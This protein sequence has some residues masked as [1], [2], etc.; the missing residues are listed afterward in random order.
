MI[1][2]QCFNIFMLNSLL[3]SQSQT[4][5]YKARLFLITFAPL[6]LSL[7]HTGNHSLMEDCKVYVFFLLQLFFNLRCILFRLAEEQ[8]STITKATDGFL[9][10]KG[11]RPARLL[12]I[13]VPFYQ[14]DQLQVKV[15]WKKTEGQWK[16]LFP[17]H[18]CKN[19]L[20]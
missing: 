18:T 10:F 15:Y 13:G 11:R 12:E 7:G 14:D 20:Y 6:S 16:A 1:G 19:A 3:M 8:V 5:H 9:S 17:S 2:S 4:V